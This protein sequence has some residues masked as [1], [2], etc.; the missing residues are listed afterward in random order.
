M[1][2]GPGAGLLIQDALVPKH[3]L[4]QAYFTRSPLLHAPTGWLLG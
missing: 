3:T 4:F 2:I 1:M